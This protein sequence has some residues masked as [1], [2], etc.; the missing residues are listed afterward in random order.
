MP[1]NPPSYIPLSVLA[2]RLN[3]HRS[4]LKRAV[5]RMGIEP[6]RVRS[7]QSN[8]QEILAVTIEEAKLIVKQRH[9][10]VLDETEAAAL[11]DKALAEDT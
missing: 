9:Q 7:V 5:Q 11:L 8:Y 3:I 1:D 2:T 10:I 4:N 6:V